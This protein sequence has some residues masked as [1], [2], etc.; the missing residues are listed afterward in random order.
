MEQRLTELEIAFSHQQHLVDEL[1]SVVLAQQRQLEQVERELQRLRQMLQ[2]QDE[3][4][5]GG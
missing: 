5:T 3:G 2:K 4:E 1:N